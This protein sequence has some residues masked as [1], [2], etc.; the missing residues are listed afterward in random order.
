MKDIARQK[1]LKILD[2]VDQSQRPLDA[3]LEE[4]LPEGNLHDKRD[5]AFIQ[6]LVY[7]VLRWRGR[8]DWVIAHFSNVKIERIDPNVLN[9]LRM[10]LFQIMFLDRVPV[11]A[12]V[13]TSVELAK[14]VAQPYVVKFVNAVLRKAGSGHT[15]VPFPDPEKNPAAAM[16]ARQSFPR[17]LVDRWFERYGEQECRRLCTFINTIP[18]ITVRVNTLKTDRD[19]LNQA[20]DKDTESAI[21]TR[22]SPV[23]ISF[24]NPKIPIAK[25]SAYQ[26]GWFQVQDE[27][28]QLVTMLLSP[29]PNQRVMDACAGLG[30]RP[31]TSLS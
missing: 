26:K 9:I 5:R 8:I 15:D 1:A 20:L 13:N 24:S 31:G 29:E 10:G 25:M 16:A 19:Q 18:P 23:G 4:I 21:P 2:I 7:G 3:V 22:S 30:A 14:S 6:T 27:A 17:W 28:A 12:A 11:S